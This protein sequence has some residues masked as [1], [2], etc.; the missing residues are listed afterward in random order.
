MN[1]I[2][3]GT[4]GWRAII[5]QDFNE[6]NVSLASQAIANYLKSEGKTSLVIGYDVRRQADSFA[7][8]AAQIL[9]A[10][11]IKVYLVDAPC[12]TP[13]TGW[14]I[15]DYQTDGAIMFTAS[16]NPQEFLGLKY[17]TEDAM[18]APSSITNVF[19]SNLAKI[20][21]KDIQKL[22]FDEAVKHGKIEIFNP[23]PGY[24]KK[25]SELVDLDKIRAAKLK[26]L[27]NPMNGAGVGYLAELLKGG[28][29]Q[30]E[31][32]NNVHAADFSGLVPEPIVEKNV[33]DAIAEVKTKKFDICL[34]LDGD[35]D[36]IGLIDENGQ[37]VS[38]L[39][40]FLMLSYYFL[41]IK[42]QRG[43]IVKTLS[44]TI[45]VDHLAKKYGIEIYETK[46]GFK[47]VGEKMKE[48]KAIFGGEESGGSAIAGFMLVRDAQIMSLFILDLMVTL[49]KPISK[50][51]ALAEKVS[52][53]RYVFK[54]EDVHFD[55]DAY[56]EIKNK[57]APEL[58]AN[59]PEK[60]LDKKVVHTRTD[61]GLKMFFKD[62][63]WLLIRFSGTEPVLRLYAEAKTMAEVDALIG[64]A[65]DYFQK[66][67]E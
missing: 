7:R 14:A 63:S 6:E 35:A 50:I 3:F 4:D 54:R 48:T 45:M 32:I 28:D 29:L 59:P 13:A 25:I 66:D 47:Y 43:A 40:A 55:Y 15:I 11:S 23:K 65:K 26:I 57:K 61:D 2:K 64:Y 27:V 24:F 41:E 36:R 34:S 44:N 51:L 39:E 56:E 5:D 10:N 20:T 30:V 31:T 1:K 53:G 22:G 60:I 62:D 37:M 12:P 52:G 38:S 33:A 49:G 16:H 42:G 58:V 67:M 9:A 17:M 21:I 19:M 46:V 18:V 8:L